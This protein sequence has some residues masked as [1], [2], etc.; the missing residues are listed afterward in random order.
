[1]TTPVWSILLVALTGSLA[2]VAQVLLKIGTR[3]ISS[4]L[5]SWVFNEHL[6]GGLALYGVGFILMVSAL[7]H[8]NVSILYPVLATSY[9]WV[10]LLS[11]FFLSEPFPLV[12]WIGVALIIG[13][14]GVIVR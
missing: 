14:I 4:T 10:A 2:A 3:S 13:G 9:I 12:R 8:G 7:R 6:L 5:S 1:M 11:T